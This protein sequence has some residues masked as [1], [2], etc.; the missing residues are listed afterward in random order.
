M[1]LQKFISIFGGHEALA[2]CQN[3]AIAHSNTF[4][5]GCN[6]TPFE[7]HKFLVENPIDPDQFIY[8]KSDWNKLK[9]EIKDTF[10]SY[11]SD[12]SYFKDFIFEIC[13]QLRHVA[14]YFFPKTKSK[15][16]TIFDCVVNT[17]RKAIQA[18]VAE[19]ESDVISSGVTNPKWNREALRSIARIGIALQKLAN[20]IQGCLYANGISTTL[21]QYQ[22]KCGVTLTTEITVSSLAEAMDWTTELA[23]YWMRTKQPGSSTNLSLNDIPELNQAIRDGQIK[24]DGTLKVAQRQIIIYFCKNKMFS[25]LDKEALDEIDGLLKTKKGVTLRSSDLSKVASQLIYHGD[26]LVEK[27]P[28]GETEI[29]LAKKSRKSHK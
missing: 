11:K 9:R 4:L 7:A 16:S 14:A 8:N 19:S 21:Y 17:Y 1:A 29:T 2:L 20:I 3:L 5:Q 26:I 15:T 18:Q 6:I 28:T 10:R 13:M 25:S 27:S 24:E 12:K 23:Q 22:K